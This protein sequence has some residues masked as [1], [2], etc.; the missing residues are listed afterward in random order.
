M[1]KMG[2]I[3]KMLALLNVMGLR[4]NVTGDVLAKH[5]SVEVNSGAL[6]NVRVI[7]VWVTFVWVSPGRDMIRP[8]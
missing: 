1:E 8:Q 3:M 5:V 4:R 6:T 7:L 2:R